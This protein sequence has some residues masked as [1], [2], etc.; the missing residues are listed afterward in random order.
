MHNT[1]LH[2]TYSIH[3]EHHAIRRA[4][5]HD[6]PK[7]TIYVVTLTRHG[8]ITSGK[9]CENCQRLLDKYNIFAIYT[10]AFKENAA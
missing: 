4:R 1:R 2:S 8:N 6:L 9:P 7:T 5:N 10:P 3:A